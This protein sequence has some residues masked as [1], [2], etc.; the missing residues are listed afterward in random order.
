[1]EHLGRGVIAVNQGNGKVF[2]SW[3]LLGTDPEGTAFN[4]YRTGSGAEPVKLNASPITNAT[5]F[6]D[7]LADLAGEYRY[8]VRPVLGGAE[9]EPS[10]SLLETIRAPLKPTP[11]FEVPLKLPPGTRP[12]EASVG[13][14][15]GDGEY[16]L[17]VEGS[18]RPLDTAARGVTGNTVLQA[19]RLDGALLW[20]IQMGRN[21]REGEHDTQSMVYDLD[22]DGIAEIALRTADGTVDGAGKVIGDASADWV[23]RRPKSRTYGKIMAGPEYFSIFDGKTGAELATVPYVPG[24]EPA[25]GWGGIGGN[26]GMEQVSE[27][28]RLNR[29]LACVA[30]LDGVRPSVVMCRGYYGRTV[31]AAWDWRDRKLTPRWVFDSGAH[32]NGGH[33]YVTL[34]ATVDPKVG[35]NR[36]TDRAGAWNGVVAGQWMIW[37][38]EGVKERRQVLAASGN[39]VTVDEEVTPGAN[40]AA[41]VYGYSGMGNHNL[42]V[43]HVDD[44]GKDEIVYGAMVVDDDGRGLFT[45]GLRHG[46]S[47]HVG[48]LDPARPGLEVF[49][50]HENEGGAYDRWTP[51]AALYDAR[52]GKVLWST[53]NGQDV[54]GGVSGD[55]DPRYPGEELWGILGGLHSCRGER[56]S[57]RGPPGGGNSSFVVWWDGDEL[58][59]VLAGNRVVKWDWVNNTA[60]N[61]LVAEGCAGG[62]PILTAD[63]AGDWREEIIFR[64]A[65]NSAL[66][67][68]T[69]TTPSDIRL[70]TLMHDPQYRLSIAWQNV[71]YN[72]PPHPGFFLGHGMKPPPRPRITSVGMRNRPPE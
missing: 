43:A 21:I 68:F 26:S 63:I 17:V 64:T 62:R 11:Y 12:I 20:T 2:V 59:E 40:K 9:G 50:P 67:V 70:H 27:G 13:D 31:L 23:D 55:I 56:I 32:P 22:G 39:V 57:S 61:L 45:T 25:G 66:R 48:D 60:T 47:L 71:G 54:G 42:S 16:D 65:D 8:F 69:T 72:Q 35:L 34:N 5:C 3:R 14:L 41:H 19:S 36:I 53:A 1:M 52:T 30:Y 37:D 46:D 28:N 18:Q 4:V 7:T 51:G 29:F 58:R 6:Q 10:R 33:P 38:R 49:G 15:D 24:R 44:D